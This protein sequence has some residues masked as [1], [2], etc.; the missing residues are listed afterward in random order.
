M[1]K[2]YEMSINK[3]LIV[4]KEV[5]DLRAANEKKKKKRKRSRA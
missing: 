2:A 5:Y 4:W 3:L 1:S